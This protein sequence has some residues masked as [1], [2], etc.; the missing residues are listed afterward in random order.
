MV[1]HQ[2]RNNQA[3]QKKSKYYREIISQNI[4]QYL[5]KH[6][7]LLCKFQYNLYKYFNL[8]KKDKSKVNDQKNNLPIQLISRNQLTINFS[9]LHEKLKNCKFRANKI[10]NHFSI[11]KFSYLK[12]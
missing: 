6:L 5:F 7:I 2:I 3:F 1:S 11:K 9:F 12:D 8:K 4:K 10:L